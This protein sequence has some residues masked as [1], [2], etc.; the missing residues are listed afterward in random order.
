M[1]IISIHPE[2]DSKHFLREIIFPQPLLSKTSS[3]K[4]ITLYFYDTIHVQGKIYLEAIV[5]LRKPADPPNTF[6][7]ASG[8][9]LSIKSNHFAQTKSWV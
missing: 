8:W 4:L 9:S 5:H 3:P 2:R 7:S 6:H 1:E